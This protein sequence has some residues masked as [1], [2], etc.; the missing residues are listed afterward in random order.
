MHV[1]RLAGAFVAVGAG[2]VGVVIGVVTAVWDC[3]LLLEA[4]L[5]G[6]VDDSEGSVDLR[7]VS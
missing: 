4:S 5:L 7:P 1:F 6:I 2:N 3:S